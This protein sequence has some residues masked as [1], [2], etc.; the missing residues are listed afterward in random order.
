[1]FVFRV[2]SM[3]EARELTEADPAVKSGRLG[4]RITSLVFPKGNYHAAPSEAV[5]R[6]VIREG[7]PN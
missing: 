4:G 5:I 3:A 7:A 6:F 1:M 2:D